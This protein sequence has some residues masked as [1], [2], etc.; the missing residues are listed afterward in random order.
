MH[1][2]FGAILKNPLRHRV[3]TVQATRLRKFLQSAA[4]GAGAIFAIQQIQV[5]R[6][7]H[8]RMRPRLGV[9]AFPRPRPPIGI[10]KQACLFLVRFGE[11][12]FMP[13]IV[14]GL[15]EDQRLD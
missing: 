2:R 7:I 14:I 6:I 10:S 1:G 12:D 15:G 3:R 9:P 4:H 13:D 8:R 5:L 11:D